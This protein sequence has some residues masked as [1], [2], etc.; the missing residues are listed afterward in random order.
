ML[1]AE[2]REP[3]RIQALREAAA[4]MFLENGYDALSI[5]A[6]IE[7]VGGSRRNVY[8]H[9]GGKEQLFIEAVQHRCLE[10]SKPLHDLKIEQSS[11]APEISLKKFGRA[12]INIVLAPETLALHRLMIAEGQRFP[13]LAE[14]IWNSGPNLSRQML[15]KWVRHQQEIGA[16][17]ADGDPFTMASQF[18]GLAT[19]ELQLRAL[20]GDAAS[21]HERSKVLDEAIATFMRGSFTAKPSENPPVAR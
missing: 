1:K 6:L 14:K 4:D 15:E 20:I 2:R 17:R 9:F 18:V 10:L 7:R 3:R 12:L 19:Y 21:E 13:A 11:E 16:S 5:E 8:A